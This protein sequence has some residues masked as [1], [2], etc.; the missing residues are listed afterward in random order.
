MNMKLHI[1]EINKYLLD[2]KNLKILDLRN[3]EL[4]SLNCVSEFLARNQVIQKLNLI[5]NPILHE[6]AF[7]NLLFGIT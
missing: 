6:K 5:G 1:K 4:K 2:H 3:N 7:R